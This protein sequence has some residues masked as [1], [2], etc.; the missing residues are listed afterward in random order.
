M[1][2]VNQGANIIYAI[3]VILPAVTKVLPH[4]IAYLRDVYQDI[5]AHWDA[6]MKSGPTFK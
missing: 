1:H 6:A 5:R 4:L 3:S 2:R